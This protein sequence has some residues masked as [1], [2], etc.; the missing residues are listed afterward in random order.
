MSVLLHYTFAML[1]W[2]NISSWLTLW[3]RC[4]VQMIQK[5]WNIAQQLS[6]SYCTCIY[7]HVQQQLQVV[8]KFHGQPHVALVIHAKD[9]L[10]WKSY[11]Y[12]MVHCLPS[13]Q[14]IRVWCCSHVSTDELCYHCCNDFH[15][16]QPNSKYL[17]HLHMTTHS[18]FV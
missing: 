15:E 13:L 7:I 5:H 9:H 16:R 11:Y 18:L 1:Q 3:W 10:V 17:S 2:L 6:R 8:Y 12:N 4:L 14:Q